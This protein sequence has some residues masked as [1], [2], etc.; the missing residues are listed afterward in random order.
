MKKVYIN[1]RGIET[2]E[3]QERYEKAYKVAKRKAINAQ[4]KEYVKA[5][6]DKEMA[7]VMAKVDFDC[8][9]INIVVMQKGKVKNMYEYNGIKERLEQLKNATDSVKY[10]GLKNLDKLISIQINEAETQDQ[11]NILLTYRRKTRLALR[12]LVF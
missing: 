6:I 11:I 4:V 2:I 1:Q 3:A 9:L 7:R 12:K 10:K 5:G 8:G